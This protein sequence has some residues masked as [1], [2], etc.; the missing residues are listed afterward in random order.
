[1]KWI[2]AIRVTMGGVLCAQGRP[3]FFASKCRRFWVLRCGLWTKS[4]SGFGSETKGVSICYVPTSE[5]TCNVNLGYCKASI[6]TKKEWSSPLEQQ[7]R[8]PSFASPSAQ[9]PAPSHC[10]PSTPLFSCLLM[11][12][13]R[14][15]C[16]IT[17]WV[18]DTQP[19][20][21][22]LKYPPASH[23]ISPSPFFPPCQ[24]SSPCCTTPVSPA[25]Q[26]TRTWTKSKLHVRRPIHLCPLL[27]HAH[28]VIYYKLHPT[29]PPPRP[30]FVCYVHAS[31]I[32]PQDQ[33]PYWPWII[34]KAVR[35][36]V[37]KRP[38]WLRL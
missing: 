18:P 29:N 2:G 24:Q 10:Q 19:P 8:S 3:Q 31:S 26:V 6:K 14:L 21:C 23:S 12:P 25:G 35:P 32:Q 11:S 28:H 17:Y 34:L 1:M 30:R 36:A 9:S 33:P 5:D 22:I 27:I 7:R 15:S 20:S 4:S 38:S 13:R 16:S 37:T